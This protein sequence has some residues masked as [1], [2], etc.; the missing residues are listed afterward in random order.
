MVIHSLTSHVFYPIALLLVTQYHFLNV[1]HLE[2][3]LVF[4]QCNFLI[5]QVLSEY[6]EEAR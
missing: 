3:S 2:S 1:S 4:C 5:L 6:K